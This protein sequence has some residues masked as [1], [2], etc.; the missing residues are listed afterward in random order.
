MIEGHQAKRDIA[1]VTL[2]Y[3]RHSHLL[4]AV[5]KRSIDTSDGDG[6]KNKA[7]HNSSDMLIISQSLERT[8]CA[9]ERMHRSSLKL[10]VQ[11][12]RLNPKLGF[13]VSSHEEWAH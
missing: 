12:R 5:W 13:T 6:K 4:G 3:L 7:D 11:S 8:F 9:A 2:D 10:L 1:R